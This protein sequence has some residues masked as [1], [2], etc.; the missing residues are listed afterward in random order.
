MYALL[1]QKLREPVGGTLGV[2]LQPVVE[3][4]E[5]Y[6]EA[7]RVA[8]HPLEVVQKR[9]R[10]VPLHVRPVAYGA[11][12]RKE[13]LVVE[14]YPGVILQSFLEWKALVVGFVDA[15]FSD[16]DGRIAIVVLNIKQQLTE[17]L[18]VHEEPS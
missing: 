18:W 12:Q 13:V 10:E 6:P 17:A 1:L 3:V 7:N 5:V 2:T 8:V 16:I 14:L 15:I 9:P 11:L 4:D